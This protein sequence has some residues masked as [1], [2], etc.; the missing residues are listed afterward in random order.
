MRFFGGISVAFSVAFQLFFWRGGYVI[1]G[2]ILGAAGSAEG[3]SEALRT[4]AQAICVI[5]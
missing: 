3:L 2:S 5:M 1:F 4:P